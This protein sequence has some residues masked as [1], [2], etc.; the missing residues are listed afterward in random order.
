MEKKNRTIIKA[1]IWQA[2]GVLLLAF[3][4]FLK[5]GS[6][7]IGA[8]ISV[9]YYIMRFLLYYLYER[10]WLKIKHGK[11]NGFCLWLTGLSGAGKSTI[12]ELVAKELKKQGYN[13]QRLD[14][15]IIR[16][17][18]LSKDLGFTKEDREKNLKRTAVLAKFLVENNVIVIASYISPFIEIRNYL[19]KVIPNFIEIY[20]ET[21]IDECIRRDPKGLYRKVLNGEIKNFTGFDSPYEIPINPDFIVQTTKE[22]P[23]QSAKKLIRYLKKEGLI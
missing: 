2:M 19:R 20:V 3:V 16:N 21:T 1:T 22:T 11:V 18:D 15:D 6:I 12:A 10:I 8:S 17:T 9:S 7:K 14:G 23:E 13:V 4:S 5:T